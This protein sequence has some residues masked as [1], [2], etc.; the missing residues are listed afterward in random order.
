MSDKNVQELL[1]IL[2]CSNESLNGIDPQEVAEEY[3]RRLVFEPGEKWK[4]F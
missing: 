2:K 3:N 1:D 4:I